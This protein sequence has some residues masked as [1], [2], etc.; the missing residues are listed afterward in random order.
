MKQAP[1]KE[2]RY[3]IATLVKSVDEKKAKKKVI[4]K[5]NIAKGSK[6]SIHLVFLE[7]RR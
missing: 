4:R 7:L 5:A 1:L 3:L 2:R 6:C